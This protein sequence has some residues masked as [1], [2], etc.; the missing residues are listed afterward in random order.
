MERFI[1]AKLLRA[2]LAEIDSQL[3][4]LGFRNMSSIVLVKQAFVSIANLVDFELTLRS[5]YQTH[6]E[7]SGIY[8]KASKEY[9]FAK[10]LRNKYIG[11][12]N[13]ELI[14]KAMEWKPELRFMLKDTDRPDVMFLYNLWVL[15]TAINSYVNPDGTHKLFESETDL[16]YPPDLRRF[17]IFLTLIVKSGIEYLDALAGSLS[18]DIEI[19]EH[20]QQDLEHWLAAGKTDFKYIKK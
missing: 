12:I 10:Y 19:P 6:R 14:E 15:E 2:D 9:E 18:S 8:A 1:E 13:S 4:E 20:T 16:I 5:I 7:L 11:H 3:E 17:L